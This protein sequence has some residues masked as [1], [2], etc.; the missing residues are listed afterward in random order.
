MCRDE[1]INRNNNLIYNDHMVLKLKLTTVLA[2][3]IYAEGPFGLK[4]HLKYALE[5]S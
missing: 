3:S 2:G 5:K 4:K 1:I